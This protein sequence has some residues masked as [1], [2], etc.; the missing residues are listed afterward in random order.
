M[1]QMLHLNASVWDWIQMNL[2]TKVETP[3]NVKKEI[4]NLLIAEVQKLGQQML[5]NSLGKLSVCFSMNNMFC[6]SPIWLLFL[7]ILRYYDIMKLITAHN[8]FWFLVMI[9]PSFLLTSV[10]FK[11]FIAACWMFVS[12]W[13]L[14][15]IFIRRI[16]IHRRLWGWLERCLAYKW[17]VLVLWHTP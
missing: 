6:P 7:S 2:R 8:C 11:L 10:V 1:D 16:K 17:V 14:G 5:A 15:F 13:S 3:R 9:F 4:I 12:I